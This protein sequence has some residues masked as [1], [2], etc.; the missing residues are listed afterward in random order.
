MKKKELLAMP[1]VTAP[2]EMIAAAMADQPYT[3]KRYYHT[4]THYPHKTYLKCTE[5][6]GVLKACFFLRD[7]LITGDILPAYELY[8]S[9]KER[10]FITF[11]RLENR[12]SEAKLDRIDWPHTYYCDRQAWIDPESEQTIKAYFGEENGGYH[13]LL[14]FQR[15]IREEQ[16]LAR[17]KR[18]T[19]PWDEDMEQV[20]ELPKDW[21]RWAGR[22]G[23]PEHFIYYHYKKRGA[24]VGYCTCCEQEV[25]IQKP[26]NNK[27]GR[28]PRC[29]QKITFKA[30]GKAG[31]VFTQQYTAYLI[32]S[33]RDGFVIREFDLQRIHPRDGRYR[34]AQVCSHETRRV[35]YDHRL[36]ARAYYWGVYKQKCARWIAGAP[37]LPSWHGNRDGLI[38]GRTLP[39]LAKKE[40]KKTGLI[41]WIARR[42]KADP[43]RYLEALRRTPQLEQ[44]TKA[45]LWRLAEEC[46]HQNGW[47]PQKICFYS[48]SSLT[49]MLGLHPKGLKRLR[50]N[51]GGYLFLSWLQH[52]ELLESVALVSFPTSSLASSAEEFCASS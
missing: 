49:G 30:A 15:K 17:H 38:Y 4:E 8:I 7:S 22:V 2:P 11:D 28:C 42:K 40:L 50:Q 32:Q 45:D 5:S 35:I 19:D 6:K 13:E 25:P 18:E 39:H 52:E 16:L 14:S 3:V 29:R 20:P 36:Q 27:Q 48:S 47:F 43:E 21:K 24:K 44:I 37:M 31:R 26:R 1:Q 10:G 9:K 12:W 51:D 46:V 33:C 23:V 34:E 41:Q